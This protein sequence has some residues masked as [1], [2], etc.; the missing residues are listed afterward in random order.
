MCDGRQ[1]CVD[2]VSTPKKAQGGRDIGHVLFLSLLELS[3]LQTETL[4]RSA[5]R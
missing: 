5:A 4:S 1:C 2:T 3:T